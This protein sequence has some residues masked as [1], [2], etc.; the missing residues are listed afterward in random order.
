MM[1][2]SP[3]FPIPRSTPRQIPRRAFLLAAASL[4][5]V[6]TNALSNPLASDRQ[7]QAQQ[8]LIK[9][10]STFGGRLGVS[11]LD[12]ASGAQLAFR[13]SERFPFCST[14]KLMLVAAILKQSTVRDGLMQRRIKYTQRDLV[15]YS[16]IT[17]DHLKDGMTVAG[18]CAAAMQ[19][20]DNSAANLLIAQLG[21][22]AAVTAFARSIGD[23]AFRLDRLETMLNS[24]LPGD[25]RDTSTPEAMARSLQ[26]LVLGDALP[27]PQRAQL[28]DWM[29]GNTTGAA[30][31]RA[32]VPAD[33]QVADKTGS[34]DYGVAND[35]GVLWPA[36]RAPLVVAIYSM[37]NE[38]DA[39]ARNDLI[40]SAARIV[41]EWLG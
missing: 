1:N 37:Q 7:Q 23:Q 26:R 17:E 33:W 24:A 13:A 28:R 11:A 12:T 9:L 30:R 2:P 31:I 22:P 3:N 39:K 19:Y 6:A 38:P 36:G 18:L 35:I 41:V 4:P 32:G 10:E 21:A 15:R 27:L 29:R 25:E 8:A 40:A 5:L 20:S 14:F 16:P 34:G